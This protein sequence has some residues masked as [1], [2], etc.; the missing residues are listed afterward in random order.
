[1]PVI[2]QIELPQ[3][4]DWHRTKREADALH[5]EKPALCTAHQLHGS[6][7][8]KRDQENHLHHPWLPANRLPSCLDEGVGLEFAPCR[9]DERGGC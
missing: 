3:C 5:T 8:P 4:G 2:H 6:G 7:E 9:R 1:M